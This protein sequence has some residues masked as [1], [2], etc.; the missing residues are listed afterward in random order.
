MV[1]SLKG[2]LDVV[3]ALVYS[4]ADIHAHTIEGKSVYIFDI[5]SFKLRILLL[6]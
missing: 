5:Q 1:A 6:L 4:G 3:R 2:H